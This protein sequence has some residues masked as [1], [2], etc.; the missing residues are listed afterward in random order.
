MSL[1]QWPGIDRNDWMGK[2]RGP[3]PIGNVVAEIMA[4]RGL[5][6]DR[7]AA[8]KRDIWRQAVGDSVAALTQ[9]GEMRG[10]RLEIMVAN[11]MLIQEL[12]FRKAEIIAALN[13][14]ISGGNIQDIR[15]RV[16][17]LGG[18]E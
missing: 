14:N 10:G 7:V 2:P 6:R 11:S 1:C 8:N 3:I 4:R 16:G 13:K 17:Q 9:C 15:F 18:A 12:T 5:G